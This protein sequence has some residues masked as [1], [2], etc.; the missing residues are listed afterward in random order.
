MS[1]VKMAQKIKPRKRGA[2]RS[3]R[4]ALLQ[5][6]L[7]KNI[8]Q[9]RP[10]PERFAYSLFDAELKLVQLACR[11]HV[12]FDA[13]EYRWTVM[14]RPVDRKSFEF[15][16]KRKNDAIYLWE[17][18]RWVREYATPLQQTVIKGFE[19]IPA[20]LFRVEILWSG[21]VSV[22]LTKIGYARFGLKDLATRA[23]AANMHVFDDKSSIA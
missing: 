13:S 8:N 22:S 7:T 20:E 21:D 10:V 4:A 5:M 11:M 9:R 17:M 14:V 23:H 18:N 2:V 19:E 16:I 15:D 6:V 12:T 3:D 1:V